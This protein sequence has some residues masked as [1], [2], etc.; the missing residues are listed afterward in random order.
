M[1]NGESSC[2]VESMGVADEFLGFGFFA[3]SDGVGAELVDGLWGEAEVA[4]DWNA[5]VEY[6]FDGWYD[7]YSAFELESVA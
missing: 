3:C 1:D 7:F 4:A 2:C 6:L 5:G